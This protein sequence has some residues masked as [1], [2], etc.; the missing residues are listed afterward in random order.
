MVHLVHCK[1]TT[2][3]HLEVFI[4]LNKYKFYVKLFPT[5]AYICPILANL[6]LISIKNNAVDKYM[7]DLLKHHGQTDTKILKEQTH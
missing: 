1:V 3:E 2:V 7:P 5:R 6:F 4:Q